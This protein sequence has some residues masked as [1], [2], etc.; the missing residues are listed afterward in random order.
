[1]A[2]ETEQQNPYMRRGFITA[3]VIVAVLIIVGGVVIFNGLAKS[4][5]PSTDSTPTPQVSIG[6]TPSASSAVAG[7]ASVC[8]LDAVKMTG[9]LD[10][11]PETTWDYAGTTAFPVSKEFGPGRQIDSGIQTC[12]SRTPGGAVMAA[13][14]GI[15]YLLNSDTVR[16]WQEYALASGSIRDELLREP[17]STADAAASTMRSSVSGFRLL[18]Y[19]GQSANVDVAVTTTLKGKTTY[20]SVVMPLVWE[21][22]DW[23]ANYSEADKEIQPAMLPNIAGYV[24]W[25]G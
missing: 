2:D 16:P 15:G 10:R 3:A 17:P 22:G 1:M 5:D 12:F 20:M 23:R 24:Q 7:G 6:A 9:T 25:E 8:G 21:N 14:V 13:S 19:D 18:K 11:A 4:D